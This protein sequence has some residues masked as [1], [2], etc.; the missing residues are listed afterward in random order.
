MNSKIIYFPTVTKA[1]KSCITTFNSFAILV[2]II[3]TT[4][5][6]FIKCCNTS[7]SLQWHVSHARIIGMINYSVCVVV[8]QGDL[9]GRWQQM[10]SL[11]RRIS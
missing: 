10:K 11:L 5:T 7:E 1:A 4:T 3:T 2:I 9:H 6:Q 8:V